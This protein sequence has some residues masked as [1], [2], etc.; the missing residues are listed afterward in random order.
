MGTTK[1]PFHQLGKQINESLPKA[2][3]K[4]SNPINDP[5]VEKMRSWLLIGLSVLI[6]GG[7]LILI[8]KS[9]MGKFF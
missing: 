5:L 2:R 9:L 8:I 1:N 4:N 3:V 6:G 7:A